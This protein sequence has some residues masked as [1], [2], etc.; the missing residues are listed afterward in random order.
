MLPL[1]LLGDAESGV[2]V[3]DC[4]DDRVRTEIA[5]VGALDGHGEIGQAGVAD[6]DPGGTGVLVLPWNPRCVPPLT[7]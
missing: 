5:A 7:N 2:V 6:L 4:R 3:E 1:F